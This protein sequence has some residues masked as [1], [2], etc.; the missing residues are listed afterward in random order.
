MRWTHKNVWNPLPVLLLASLLLGCGSETGSLESGEWTAVTD[1]VGEFVRVRT[2]SGSVW[3]DSA[4]LVPEI[5]IGEMDGPDEYVFGSPRGLEVA[6]DGT[7]YVLDDQ[8]PILR[9]YGPDG[10]FLRNVGRE[11]DGPGEYNSPDGMGILP[12][13]RIL[14]RDPPNSRIAVYAASGEYLTQWHLTGG[15]NS[16]ARTYVDQDGNS[17][18]ITLLDRGVGPWDWEFG[19]VRYAPDGEIVDTVAA[20]TWDYEAPQLTAQGEGSSSVRTVPFSPEPAWT[21]SRLG[22]MVG[23]LSTD[24]R[25]DLFRTD[26]PPLRIEREWVPETVSPGEAFERRRRLTQRF[27]RQYGSWR[28]N[29]PD[30]PE[31]KPPFRELLTSW[32]GDIWVVLSAEGV[33]IMSE[34]EAREEEAATGILPLRFREHIAFD[35]FSPD[36]AFLGPVQVPGSFRIEPDPVIRGELV[37][38]V[39]R[40]ELEIPRVVRF[41]IEGR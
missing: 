35:V 1:T 4:R 16:D 28:W 3:G 9:A 5:S 26:A 33:P 32:E 25:I 11:G 17:Y 2:V 34:A 8:V 29:G 30:I 31:S 20:P 14:V 13:G 6:E 27:E 24:Y 12:D 15:F 23:G 36:G 21:F 7:I 22:Y 38:A 39:T 18:A 19:L 41:R 37:W 40:D 10:T